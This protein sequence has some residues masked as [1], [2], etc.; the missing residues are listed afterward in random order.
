MALEFSIDSIRSLHSWLVVL[1]YLY[2][3]LSS[4]FSWIWSRRL[5]NLVQG[6]NRNQGKLDYSPVSLATTGERRATDVPATDKPGH[7][8]KHGVGAQ[9]L[10]HHPVRLGGVCPQPLLHSGKLKF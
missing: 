9:A 8:P 1:S 3:F 5:S 6:F 4:S 2:L 7:G 10:A